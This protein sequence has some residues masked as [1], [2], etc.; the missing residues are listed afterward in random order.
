PGFGYIGLF[1]F[2]HVE[3]NEP[4][5][6]ARVPLAPARQSTERVSR[7]L[8]A[9]RQT[10]EPDPFATSML[11]AGQREIRNPKSNNCFQAPFEG[12]PDVSHSAGGDSLRAFTSVAIGRLSGR[13][14][15]L[16]GKANDAVLFNGAD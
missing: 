12:L 5:E 7:K 2:F 4:K 10:R 15:W 16:R 9:L 14:E 8:A 11:G 3:E 13:L 1:I 6:D